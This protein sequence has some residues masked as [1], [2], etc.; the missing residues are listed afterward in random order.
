[1]TLGEDYPEIREAVRRLCVDFPGSYWRELETRE[2]YPTKFVE[3]LTAAGYLGV[4][5]PEGY[6]GAGLPLRA[7][8]VDASALPP[9]ANGTTIRTGF[10]G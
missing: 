3:T 2:A 6:G 5:I 10:V 9:G 7:A 4:L 1:M 8:L